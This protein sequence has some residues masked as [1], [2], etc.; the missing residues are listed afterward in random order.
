MTVTS[1]TIA[2]QAITYMGDNQAAVTGNSPNFD[3]S[4]AGKTLQ[5]LYIPCV[6]TV[7]RRFGWDFSR[8]Q[9]PLTLSGNPAGLFWTYEYLYPSDCVQLRQLLP[10]TLL[11]PY[12]PAPITWIVANS[13][14][15]AIPTKV[16]QTNL[17]SAHAVYTNYPPEATW[18]SLF[19][20]SVVRLLAS[21]LAIAIAGRPD[22][23]RE[24]ETSGEQFTLFAETR[25]S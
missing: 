15:S 3:N 23:A 16:I 14:V 1:N 19:R 21:E 6:Q 4:T 5:N 12:D 11:D 13:L 8:F 24:M 25:G 10:A 17:I 9:G 2:N 7:G 20:E 18:D 22:T